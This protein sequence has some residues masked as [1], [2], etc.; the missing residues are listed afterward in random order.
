MSAVQIGVYETNTNRCAMRSLLTAWARASSIGRSSFSWPNRYRPVGGDVVWPGGS[1][2]APDDS[3]LLC[4]P[5]QYS[6]WNMSSGTMECTGCLPGYYSTTAI[7]S[8]C[9]ACPAGG[10]VRSHALRTSTLSPVSRLT[11]ER[12]GHFAGFFTK[13]AAQAA[14]IP[15]AALGNFYQNARNGT[16][17]ISC[18]E[19]TEAVSFGGARPHDSS[20]ICLYAASCFRAVWAAVDNVFLQM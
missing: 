20:Q 14:C 12:C 1:S 6:A 9:I 2:A 5:G 19:N 17:C 16:L 18:P 11:A 4:V 10:G 7:T 3:Y 15:C 8:A 13:E